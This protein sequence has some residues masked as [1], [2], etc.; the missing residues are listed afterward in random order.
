MTQEQGT[1]VELAEDEVTKEQPTDT[2]EEENKEEQDEGAEDVE[3]TEEGTEEADTEG[4]EEV[5]EEPQKPTRRSASETIRSLKA[6]RNAER[7]EREK[8]ISERATLA[9]QLEFQ[10]QRDN[11]SLSMEQRRAEES[12]LA[13]LAPE[14][15]ALYE[16]NQRIRQMEHRMNQMEVQRQDDRD[17]AEFHAKAMHDEV[18]SK[19]A[20]EIE[21]T[22]QDGLRKGVSAPRED[23]LAWKLGKELLKDK[24][25][26]ASTKKEAAG[27]RIASVTSKPARAKGDVSGTKSGK[28]EEDRLRGVLI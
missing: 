8:L 5:S 22:Y 21:Q 9:A 17:R 25:S 2:T 24:N 16:A 15:R 28:S 6:E 13:L 19:Y 7:A 14:E 23:L 20:D 10:R 12:R 11:Q 27:K 26:K 18:Y 4:T 1:E 3:E